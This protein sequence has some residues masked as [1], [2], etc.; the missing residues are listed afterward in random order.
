MNGHKVACSEA[1]LFYLNFEFSL[2]H[3]AVQAWKLGIGKYSEDISQIHQGLQSIIT[4]VF[5][6]I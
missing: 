5:W 6:Y 3:D 4:K 2:L 1:F